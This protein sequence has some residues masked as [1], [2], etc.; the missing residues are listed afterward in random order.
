MTRSIT[1]PLWL[2]FIG[3][4]ATDFTVILLMVWGGPRIKRKIEG[5][6]GLDPPDE[7]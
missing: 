2:F 3:L 6:R 7:P 4:W 1:I 5:N